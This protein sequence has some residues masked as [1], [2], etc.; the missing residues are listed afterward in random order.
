MAAIQIAFMEI[1]SGFADI[2]L[3]CGMEHMTRVPMGPS[4]FEN[5][6]MSINKALY[7]A[8]E[9]AHWDM[10]TIMNMGLTAEKLAEQSGIT[11]KE[12]DLW[13][14]RSHRLAAQ[15]AESGFFSGEILPI[16]VKQDNG[17]VLTVNRDQAIRPDTDIESTGNLKPVFKEGG[18]ITAGNSSPLSAGAGTMLLMSEKT[19]A[20]K[21]ITPLATIRSIGFSGVDPT[22]M[23]IGPIPATR[24]ALEKAGLQA[25]DIDYWEINEAFSVVVLNTIKELGIDPEKVNIHGGS[26]A[27]GHPLGATGIRLAGTIAR[28]LAE[29]GGSLGCATACIGGGQG[30]ALIIE[31][32]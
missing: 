22:L 15:A 5:G 21:N 25:G 11:R 1:A 20:Y 32:L 12:M 28:I 13:T 2:V 18:S 16:P 7:K 4:L 3:A 31:R 17:E 24:M 14:V 6:T 8:P 29:K 23:G 10:T 9:Y 30:T 27:L 26:I 19:A